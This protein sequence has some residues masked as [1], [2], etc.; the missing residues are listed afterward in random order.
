MIKYKLWPSLSNIN[1]VPRNT[2]TFLGFYLIIMCSCLRNISM[3][4]LQCNKL[5]RSHPT[6]FVAPFNKYLVAF[7][8][9][10]TK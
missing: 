8:L 5:N 6:F 3:N 4:V 1:D 7:L 9:M 10:E 2:C